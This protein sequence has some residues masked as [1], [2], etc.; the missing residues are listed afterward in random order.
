MKLNKQKERLLRITEMN[1]VLKKLYP[2]ARIALNYSTPWECVVAVQLSAQ[3]TDERVNKTT[4][5]LFK[6]YKTLE[7]YE[8]VSQVEFEKDI[9]SCGFFRNKAKNIRLAAQIL[10]K[11]FN[12][13]VPN[14]MKDILILPGV[15][16]KTANVVLS[17]IYGINEGIAV[18]THVRRF[19]IRFDLSD[20]KDSVRIEKDLMVLLPV[21]EWGAFNHRLVHYGRDYCPARKHNCIQHP[22][23]YIYPK[24][25]DIWPRA[26]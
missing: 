17:N 15:A 24:S 23:T 11:K 3:C 13:I 1:R 2:D 12:G 22:L 18:D 26:K 8:Q 20:F 10:L 6:K 9:H 4:D 21:S 5:G 16:R 19:V 25:T 7:S 14:N